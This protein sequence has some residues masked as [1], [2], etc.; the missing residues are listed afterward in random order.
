MVIGCGGERWE[1]GG[2][3]SERVVGGEEG[4]GKGEGMGCDAHLN[5]QLLSL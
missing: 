3:V 2:R 5:H 4:E 1:G